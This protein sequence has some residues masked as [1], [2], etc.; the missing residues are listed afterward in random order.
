MAIHILN[1]I[2]RSTDNQTMKFGQVMN[3]IKEILFFKS[4]AKNEVERLVSDLSFLKKN[5]ISG[6]KL[7]FNIFRLSST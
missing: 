7:S 4:N 1:N 3:I 6:K 5:L 2:S